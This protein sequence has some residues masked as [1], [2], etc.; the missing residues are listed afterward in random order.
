MRSP[1]F[2][3]RSGPR[4]RYWWLRL[5][6]HDVRFSST[7]MVVARGCVHVNQEREAS[8]AP[9]RTL[10]CTDEYPLVTFLTLRKALD[11]LTVDETLGC[12]NETRFFFSQF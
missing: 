2:R 7:N 11:M 5:N 6:Q 3:C 10:T 1:P 8:D 4:D 9:F 12:G